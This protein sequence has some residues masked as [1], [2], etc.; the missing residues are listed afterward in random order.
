[1]C[2][3]R[4]S[5][6]LDHRLCGASD[7]SAG[8]VCNPITSEC[9]PP[10]T[11]ACDGTGVCPIELA[12]GDRC[13]QSGSFVPCIEHTSSCEGGCRLCGP[14][15]T[16]SACSTCLPSHGG[17]EVCDGFDNDCIGGVD[18][19]LNLKGCID[20]WTDRD[21]DGFGAGDPLCFCGL[22]E[23]R[24]PLGGDGDDDNPEVNPDVGEICDG[25]DNDGD[26]GTLARETDDDGDG[27]VECDDWRGTVPG[28][29]GGGDCNDLVAAIHPGAAEL[30]DGVDNSCSGLRADELDKDGDGYVACAPY[31]GKRLGIIGGND[32]APQD[33]S[34]H[35]KATEVFDSIDNNC[36]GQ[37]DECLTDCRCGSLMVSCYPLQ[38]VPVADDEGPGDVDARVEVGTGST[39]IGKVG[40][41]YNMAS[42]YYVEG[43]SSSAHDLERFSV[44]VWVRPTGAPV[45]GSIRYIVDVQS[46]YGVVQA[47]QDEARCFLMRDGGSYAIVGARD[48]LPL[49][50]WTHIGCSYGGAT[51]R[52]YVNGELRG[53]QDIADTVRTSNAGPIRIGSNSPSVGDTDLQSFSGGID[54]LKIYNTVIGDKRMCAEAFLTACD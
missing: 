38:E 19:G 27:Y 10:L 36:D 23:G 29:I 11:T 49:S 46:Q 15:N 8:Y 43:P 40:A 32:C 33:P 21:G 22:P 26:G 47:K 12:D 50:T 41:A 28:V 17:V 51:L 30:C 20:S 13:D 37:V 2:C 34:V 48:M 31:V 1:M 35:P 53:S 25:I 39:V 7:C 14:D 52:L 9:V 42:S 54:Q 16:W 6:D 24:A 5:V 45:G 4:A 18:D 44:S 3:T